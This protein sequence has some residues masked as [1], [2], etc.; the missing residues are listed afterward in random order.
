[1]IM[2]LLEIVTGAFVFAHPLA[3]AVITVSVLAYIVAFMAISFGVLGIY[4]GFQVRK[5]LSGE[6]AMIVGGFLA[7]I[8]GLILIMDPLGTAKVYLMVLGGLSLLGGIIQV[9]AA[10]QIRRIGQ[11]G[12]EAVIEESR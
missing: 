8:V 11:V 6:W 9:F 1:L 2:G 12:L 7:V 3:G 10:F 5:E 4:T